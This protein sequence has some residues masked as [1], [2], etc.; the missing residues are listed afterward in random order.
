MENFDIARKALETSLGSE[1][2]AMTEHGKW[3]ESLEAKTLQ[4]KAAWEGLSQAF[5]SDSFLKGAVDAGTGLL[6]VITQLID[7]FGTLPTLLT[8]VGLAAFIKNFD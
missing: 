6:S 3:L 8:G 1:G 4:F 7:T 5:M 2:S